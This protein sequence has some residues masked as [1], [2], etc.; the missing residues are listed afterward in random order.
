MDKIKIFKT[1]HDYVTW[2]I[3]TVHNMFN[4]DFVCYFIDEE[5]IQILKSR[6]S[7]R[8]KVDYLEFLKILKE[9][10]EKLYMKY[11]IMR[12]S[13]IAQKYDVAIVTNTQPID[14]YHKIKNLDLNV[15]CLKF[16]IQH[17]IHLDY[18]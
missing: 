18:K 3:E 4:V 5:N 13:E 6:H 15:E 12:L 2:N 10:D 9:C 11:Y 8:G 14:P 16:P 1:A 7:K 17:V